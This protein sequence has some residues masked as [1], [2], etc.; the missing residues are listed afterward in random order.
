MLFQ[1]AEPWIFIIWLLIATVLV[2][3]II[4]I[5]VLLLES[6]TKASDKKYMIII[7]AIIVVLLLPVILNAIGI[8]LTAI[9][10]A[11]ASLRNAID[12]GGQNFLINLVPVCGFLILL[13]LVKFFIDIPWD[14]SVW[15]SLLILFLLYILYSLAPE[16]YTFVGFGF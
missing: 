2:A 15:V 5:V 1:A 16:L 4:F 12:G 14:H 6:R 3:L 11:L 7:L 10:D 13:V 8:V 9:G